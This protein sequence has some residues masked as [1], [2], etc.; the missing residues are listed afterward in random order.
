MA[1]PDNYGL[2]RYCKTCGGDG[3]I[4]NPTVF[5]DSPE[6]VTCSECNGKGEVLQMSLDSLVIAFSEIEEKLQEIKTKINQMQADINYIKAKV[7]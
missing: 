2:Y 3:V 5:P 1:Y 6:N 4:P 7:G